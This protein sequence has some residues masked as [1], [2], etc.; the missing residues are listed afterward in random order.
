MT[1]TIIAARLRRVASDIEALQQEVRERD[2]PAECRSGPLALKADA[3][4]VEQSPMIQ[5]INGV[6][7]IGQGY[8]TV[9]N[10]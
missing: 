5:S 3:F 1:L 4:L 6:T 2:I 8:G 7:A 10:T 9:N